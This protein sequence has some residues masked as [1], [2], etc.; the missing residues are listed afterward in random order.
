MTL[1]VGRSSTI[2]RSSRE[3]V[4]RSARGSR[5]ECIANRVSGTE[6]TDS[7]TVLVESS[8]GSLVML[9]NEPWFLKLLSLRKSEQLFAPFCR[10]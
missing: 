3:V 9:M 2:G 6:R 4:G 7:E 10:G 1:F 8:G 5:T